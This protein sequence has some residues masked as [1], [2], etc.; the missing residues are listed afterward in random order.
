MTLLIGESTLDERQRVATGALSPLA[1]S[2]TKD[3]EP[4]LRREIFFPRHSALL[5]RAGGRCERHGVYL[6]FDPFKPYEHRCPTCGEVYTGALHH[7]FWIY[8]YQL[9]LAERAV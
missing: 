9:W 7:R 5:S 1:A 4:L 8:W 6:A 3:L 2:L